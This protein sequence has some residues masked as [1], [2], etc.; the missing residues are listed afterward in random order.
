MDISV[1]CSACMQM[2]S[3]HW[4]PVYMKWAGAVTRAGW[5]YRA[6]SAHAL[7]T[8]RRAGSLAEDCGCSSWDLHERA[9]PTSHINTQNVVMRKQGTIRARPIMRA[10]P[11]NRSCSLHINSLFLEAFL[12][13]R[14]N[15]ESIELS[16]WS[17]IQFSDN[18]DIG[19][20]YL[21]AT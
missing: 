17:L 19:T 21:S 20:V 12:R 13:L 8:F 18:I 4:R 16:L 6:G 10:S 7:F 3:S 5:L 14:R 2:F 15:K 9:S 11:A 1:Y